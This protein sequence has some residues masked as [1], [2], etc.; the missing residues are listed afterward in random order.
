MVLAGL[1]LLVFAIVVPPVGIAAL[2]IFVLAWVIRAHLWTVV[3]AYVVVLFLI[4]ARYTVGPF[5]VNAAMLLAFLAGFLWI[6]SK[7]LPY[8][9]IARG[10]NPIV[11]V[12]LTFFFLVLLDFG[13]AHT[14]PMA[15]LQSRNMDRLTALRTK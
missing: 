11:I 15:D 4:P 12:V 14:L 8:V 2:A 5:A 7:I 13:L 9:S 10:A 3:L 1:A 6:G